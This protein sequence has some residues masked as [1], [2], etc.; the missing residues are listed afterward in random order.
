MEQNF[1]E[2]P[3]FQQPDLQVGNEKFYTKIISRSFFA[4]F[5]LAAVTIVVQFGIDVIV[6]LLKPELAESGW[7][8]WALTIVSLVIIGFP[9]YY[10]IMRTIPDSPKRD[11]NKIKP[12]AFIVYF[13]MCAAAMYIT[14]FITQFINIAISLIKGKGLV[15]PAAEA[16]MNENYIMSLIYVVLIAPTLEELIFRKLLLNKLRRFGDV[17]AILLTGFAFGLFHFNLMQFFYA[18]VLGF[19]FAY[20]TLKTN[21]VRYSIILH[22]MINFIGTIVA[23]LVTDMNLFLMMMVTLWVFT[24][25]TLGVIFFIL[26]IK[27]IKLDKAQERVKASAFVCNPGAI[28]FALISVVIF[29]INTLA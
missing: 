7:Y 1:I 19:F 3:D 14:N 2:Q 10:L 8:I 4:V 5:I 24:S 16:I 12:S 11:I 23:P 25:I 29:A 13:F 26:N 17:P 15:N 9:I 21:T 18:A 28:M 22:M 6:K 20:I 27:K